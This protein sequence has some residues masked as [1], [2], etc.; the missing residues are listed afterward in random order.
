MRA[1]VQFCGSTPT[2]AATVPGRSAASRLRAI[3]AAKVAVRSVDRDAQLVLVD[4][5]GVVG[6]AA[7]LVE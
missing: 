5:A 3:S 1:I 7:P 6:P 4:E 2:I